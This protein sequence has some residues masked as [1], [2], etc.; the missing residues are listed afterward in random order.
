MKRYIHDYTLAELDKELDHGPVSI[1]LRGSHFRYE[2]HKAH[3]IT[4]VGVP[5]C[6]Y[7]V[8]EFYQGQ[9]HSTLGGMNTLDELVLAKAFPN[10]TVEPNVVEAGGVLALPEGEH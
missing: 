10:G 9:W 1:D 3:M 7:E 4:T 6:L 5:Y 2:V 8:S